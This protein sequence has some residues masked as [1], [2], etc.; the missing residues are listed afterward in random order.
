MAILGAKPWV[1]P[2]GKM[3][4]FQLFELIVFIVWKGVFFFRISKIYFPGLYCLQKKVG[5][6]P[7]LDQNHGLS[8]L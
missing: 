1:N 3:L 5:K 7:H 6:N 2:F 8:P 4:I